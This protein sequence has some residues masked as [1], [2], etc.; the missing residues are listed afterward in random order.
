M[1]KAFDKV[2]ITLIIVATNITMKANLKMMLGLKKGNMIQHGVYHQN[3]RIFYK[4]KI[5]STSYVQDCS[6][7]VDPCAP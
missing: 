4:G 6:M 2:I 7:P 3:M 5:V 1:S